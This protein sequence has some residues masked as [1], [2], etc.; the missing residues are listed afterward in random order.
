MIQGPVAKPTIED[1]LRISENYRVD[2][3]PNGSKFS[4]L[5]VPLPA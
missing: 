3:L 4:V 1:Y 2:P 5:V